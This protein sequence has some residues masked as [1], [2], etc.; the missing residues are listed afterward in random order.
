M[1]ARILGRLAGRRENE[2][3][4][5]NRVI[6]QIVTDAGPEA[7]ALIAMIERRAEDVTRLDSA[8]FIRDEWRAGGERRARL[9]AH[10]AKSDARL[11][12]ERDFSIALQAALRS[13][14]GEPLWDGTVLAIRRKVE[15]FMVDRLARRM[16]PAPSLSE[17]RRAV[18][19]AISVDRAS[20]LVVR[21]DGLI[22]LVAQ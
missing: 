22:D 10:A 1:R 8:R 21:V 3:A 16:G 13:F 6:G 7:P 11:S 5:T 15:G 9:V 18:A 12:E 2:T 14:A 19:A 20:K 17:I 4:Q